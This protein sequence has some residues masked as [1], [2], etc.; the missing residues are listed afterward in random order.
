MNDD[1][2]DVHNI[3]NPEYE[4]KLVCDVCEKITHPYHYIEGNMCIDCYEGAHERFKM[5]WISV[6]DRFPNIGDYVLT[7]SPEGDINILIFIQ[8]NHFHDPDYVENRYD[9]TYFAS[10]HNYTVSHW[11]PLPSTPE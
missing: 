8:D 2:E 10:R 5:K 11:M 4:N 1:N 6:K 9:G 7:C 3:K